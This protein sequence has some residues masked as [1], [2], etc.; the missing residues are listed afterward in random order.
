MVPVGQ[1]M[2]LGSVSYGNSV[3]QASHA[4]EKK[5]T[6]FG[7]WWQLGLV[8]ALG[9]ALPF[10]GSRAGINDVFSG[11][12]TRVPEFAGIHVDD[13]HEIIY[14]H[15]RNRNAAAAQ[16][17]VTELRSLFGRQHLRH[18]KVQVLP[19]TYG[20]SKLKH[21]HD[22]LVRDVLVQR[23]VTFSAISHSKKQARDRDRGL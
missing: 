16:A 12:A 13:E 21:W 15:L 4:R 1:S 17:V 8:L 2:S 23:G 22:D 9:I 6:R 19:A 3:R 18:S 5:P 7:R 20:F 14:V 11:I 10:G